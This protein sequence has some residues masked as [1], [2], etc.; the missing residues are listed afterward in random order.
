MFPCNFFPVWYDIKNREVVCLEKVTF[1]AKLEVFAAG[2]NQYLRDSDGDLSALGAGEFLSFSLHIRNGGLQPFR[3]QQATV[4]IDGGPPSRWLTGQVGPGKRGWLH[5]AARHMAPYMA[6][7]THT[8]EWEFDGKQAY[9]AAFLLTRQMNWQ[10]VFPCPTASEIAQYRNPHN[11]R[12]PYLTGWFLAPA[13]TRYTEYAVEFRAGHLP[14]GTYCSLGNWTMDLTD[15]RRR[16]R[17]VDAP[18]IHAYAGFQRIADG[19]TVGIMSFWDMDCTDCQ[20]NRK[21]L[22]AKREYPAQVLDGGRFDGEGTGARNSV[23]FDW[24]PGKWYRMHLKCVPS[25]ITGNTCLEQWVRDLETGRDTLLS[26]FDTNLKNSAIQGNIAVFLE[27]YL[28]QTAGE[29]RS[30]E[31]RNP[32]YLDASTG[33][34]RKFQQVHLSSQAGVPH[35]EGSYGFGVEEG[36]IWMITSGVGGDWFGNGKGKPGTYYE[37]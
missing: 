10:G 14:R 7:G 12:S 32:V 25:A 13:G 27:N 18:F 5:T 20:G 3:W 9:K 21:T 30:M 15:L 34:W 23:L 1:A 28:P 24:G 6:P 22:Q 31:V 16:Y 2:T 33:T 26:R 29:I 17:S 11:R 37:L 36:R 35:Y 19:R 8:V 4:R